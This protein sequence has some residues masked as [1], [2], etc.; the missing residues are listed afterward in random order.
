MAGALAARPIPLG[1]GGT[2][3]D[4]GCDAGCHAGS[5]L[6]RLRI[7]GRLVRR[8][9][10]ILR[11]LRRTFCGRHPSFRC[12]R[13]G[14]GSPAGAVPEAAIA[15]AEVFGNFLRDQFAGYFK[16]PWPSAP[17]A[18]AGSAFAQ[19]PPAGIGARADAAGGARRRGVASPHGGTGSAAPDVVGHFE[20]CRG[21]LYFAAGAGRGRAAHGGSDRAL[22]RPVDRCAEEPTDAPPTATL[23]AMRCPPAST[24]LPVAPR[25]RGGH[26]GMGQAL[27]IFPP[28][29]R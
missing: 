6:A 22:L 5:R 15:A 16:P 23:S 8:I 29:A 19:A 14:C 28:A 9:A 24:L 27:A 25:I 12:R 20:G 26:R 10:R 17:G 11:R 13:A 4:A 21:G 7:A 1:A 2:L 18:P 3:R